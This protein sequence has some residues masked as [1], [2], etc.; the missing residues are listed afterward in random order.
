MRV[1]AFNNVLDINYV[2]SAASSFL[3][4]CMSDMLVFRASAFLLTLPG[5][6]E[7]PECAA[8]LIYISESEHRGLD[9]PTHSSNQGT[10][11]RMAHATKRRPGPA[12][13]S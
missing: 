12:W 8:K 6:L 3:L 5:H 1:E 9:G 7:I 4:T 2:S 10:T 11:R 13:C